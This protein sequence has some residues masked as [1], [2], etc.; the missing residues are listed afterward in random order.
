[1]TIKHVYAVFFSPTGGT[2][3][4]VKAIAKALDEHYREVDLTR[5]KV[6]EE[7]KTFE[8]GD[9]VILGAP[10]YAGRLPRI[11]GG[12]FERLAG[13]G[14]WA[15]LNVSY[16]NREFDDALLEEK[17]ICEAQGFCPVA[18]AGWIAPHTFS[19]KIAEGR[20]D[21]EDLKKA[22]EFARQIKDLLAKGEDGPW[23][24]EV[25]GNH[26]YKPY[27]TISFCPQAKDGC[28]GCGTC[29]RVCPTGAIDPA[30]PDQ[31]DPA[32]C[33]ACHACIKQCPVHAR[34]VEAPAFE[35]TV[36]RLEGL[37]LDRR[38]EAETFL[39]TRG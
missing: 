39:G 23:K 17:E 19:G 9:L 34:R 27:K 11:P 12:I 29:A 22:L 32:L 16:G 36:K 30:H 38:K 18:A 6:R 5:P 24:L 7:G 3:A 28:T 15:V 33:I 8:K 20:P 21:E 10:V 14:A 35:E 2:R 25:P 13:N 1:M 26:P 31:T 4:Y 37:L